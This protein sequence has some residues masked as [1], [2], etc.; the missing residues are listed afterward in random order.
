VELVEGPIDYLKMNIEGAEQ[1]AFSNAPLAAKSIRHATISCH[2]FI[3]V[4]AKE[5]VA[6][7]FEAAGFELRHQAE[8]PHVEGESFVY[9]SNVH[10][11]VAVAT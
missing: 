2:D 5:F 7:W 8:A 1:A 9:A 11:F 3:G 10:R 6:G 4:H